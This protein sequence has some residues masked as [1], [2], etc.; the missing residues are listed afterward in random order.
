MK[1]VQCSLFILMLPSALWAQSSLERTLDL[2]PYQHQV[3]PIPADARFAIVQ[4]PYSAKGTYLLD[5]C[6]G[7]VWELASATKDSGSVWQKVAVIAQASDKR[8]DDTKINYAIF[9]SGLGL[10]YTFL[11]NI[12]TGASWECEVDANGQSVFAPMKR[13]E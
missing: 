12:R 11:I 7:T 6:L 9:I 13:G 2:P 1:I 3:T 10:R 4:A 5:R 8:D